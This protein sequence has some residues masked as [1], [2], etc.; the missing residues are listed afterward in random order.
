MFN[1]HNTYVGE[2]FNIIAGLEILND[3]TFVIPYFTA[4]S[5]FWFKENDHLIL[6]GYI[7]FAVS[8]A[9]SVVKLIYDINLKFQIA[10]HVSNL[11]YEIVNLMVVVFVIFL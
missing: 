9:L 8:V 11:F 1:V 2:N 4:N 6:I 5:F 7:L 3:N 10:I